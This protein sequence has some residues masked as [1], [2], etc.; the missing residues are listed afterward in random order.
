[1]NCHFTFPIYTVAKAVCTR[2]KVMIPVTRDVQPGDTI[3]P[4]H[5]GWQR[6]NEE[7]VKK[8]NFGYIGTRTGY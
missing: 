4:S 2:T 7:E 1:M 3:Y 6:M 5:D 8:V